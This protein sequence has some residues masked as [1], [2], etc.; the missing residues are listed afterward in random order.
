MKKY[1]AFL[2]VILFKCSFAQKDTAIIRLEK[3]LE[4]TRAITD[5]LDVLR[6]LAI[7]T[8]Y[9]QPALME[10]YLNKGIFLAEESRDKNLMVKARRYAASL[11]VSSNN[12]QE[13]ADKAKK[14]AL[15]AVQIARKEQVDDMEKISAL[16]MMAYV[17]RSMGK[18]SDGLKYNQEAV[19]IANQSG[20]DSLRVISLIGYGNTQLFLDENIIAFKSYTRALEI[21]EKS[22]GKNREDLVNDVN[23]SLVKFYVNIENYEK[24]IDYQYKML[25][26]AK[27]NKPIE[28]TVSILYEIGYNYT[29]AKKIDASKRTFEQL[30]KIGDS[31]KNS[32]YKTNAHMG[33]LNAILSDEDKSGAL[34]YLKAHPNI[35]ETFAKTNMLYQLDFGLGNTFQ[36]LKMYDSAKYYYQKSLPEIEQKGSVFVKMNMYYNYG[37]HLYSTNNYPKAIQYFQTGKTLSDSIK[38]LSYALLNIDYLDSCYQKIGDFKNAY[39][40]RTLRNK[41]K[42]EIEEKSKAKDVLALELETETKRK[43]RQAA[44]EAEKTKQRHNWQYMGIIMAI[45]SLFILLATLGIFNVPVKWVKAL[46]FIAFIFLFEFL[47]LLADTWIHHATHGEPW[48]VLAIKVILIALLLP[49]HHWLEHKAINYITTRKKKTALA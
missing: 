40:N 29:R 13:R 30:E 44:E 9:Y 14:Y 42:A 47:I 6:E 17:E 28:N 38:N 45:V 10:D 43:E 16:N 31:I 21:A 8:N 4:N 15:E 48:K 26:Y 35:K 36:V 32:D 24:A 1:F 27:A 3:K 39:L 18:A 5:K 33:I 11:F 7:K 37:I 49:F 34:E 2:L 46:G 41:V 19:E 12:S 23:N 20:V 22:R 25:A